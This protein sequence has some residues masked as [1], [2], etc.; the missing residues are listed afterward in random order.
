MHSLEK[1]I[2]EEEEEEDEFALVKRC[3]SFVTSTAVAILFFSF[4]LFDLFFALA[5]TNEMRYLQHYDMI[6]RLRK[7]IF[8]A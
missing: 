4:H 2:N 1:V 5:T 7:C 8:T 6:G 3:S